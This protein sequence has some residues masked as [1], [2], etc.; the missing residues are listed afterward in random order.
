MPQRY[1]IFHRHLLDRPAQL[2]RA[3]FN[4]GKTAGPN[5]HAHCLEENSYSSCALKMC[6]LLSNVTNPILPNVVGLPGRQ[7]YA[8]VLHLE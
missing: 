1:L 4:G 5:V 2:P 8:T 6:L 3:S 7:N